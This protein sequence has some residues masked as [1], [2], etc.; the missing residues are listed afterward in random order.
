MYREDIVNLLDYF[1]A[2]GSK[3]S[4]G[5][6]HDLGRQQHFSQ[7]HMNDIDEIGSN[8][9]RNNRLARNRL[10]YEL[11]IIR[12]S[13]AYKHRNKTFRGYVFDIYGIS[14]TYAYRLINGSISKKTNIPVSTRWR[15]WERDDFRCQYCGSRKYLVVDH[16]M[17]ESR[18]GTS[19]DSNLVT[20]CWKC[21]SA[22]GNKSGEEFKEISKMSRSWDL[23]FELFCIPEEKPLAES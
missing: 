13:K 15:I 23:F 12:D 16:V 9:R 17:P 18:G 22:K 4:Q 6:I 19:E 14:S 5:R 3:P 10:G 11:K 2:A 21:N 1:V 20:A 8:L 7:T